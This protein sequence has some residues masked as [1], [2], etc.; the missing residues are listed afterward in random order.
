[1]I[2]ILTDVAIALLSYHPHPIPLDNLGIDH[3]RTLD[4][5]RVLVSLLAGKPPY[6]FKGSTIIGTDDSQDGVERTAVL[7]GRRLDA[8][9]KRVVVA[10][11]LRVIEHPARQVG[12]ELVLP[13]V[14]IRVEERKG[15]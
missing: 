2:P 12:R 1:L 7:V 3:A 10:G 11:T 8:E 15:K 6:A 14:E 9:G 13:W 4:G 5:K